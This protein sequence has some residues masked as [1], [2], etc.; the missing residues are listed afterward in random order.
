MLATILKGSSPGSDDLARKI[1]DTPDISVFA[2]TRDVIEACRLG[3]LSDIFIIDYTIRGN[4]LAIIQAVS[5]VIS[6]SR[7]VVVGIPDDPVEI[8]ACLE[9]GAFGYVRATENGATMRKVIRDVQAGQARLD[10]NVAPTLIARLALLK[11]LQ[12]RWQSPDSDDGH[13]ASH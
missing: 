1:A 6:P 2:T 13:G 7:V 5:S 4:V 8:V 9:S 3:R 10:A 12:P 11:A